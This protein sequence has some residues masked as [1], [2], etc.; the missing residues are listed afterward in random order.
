MVVG[1][2]VRPGQ[3]RRGRGGSSSSGF[4]RG[5]VVRLG[6]GLSKIPATFSFHLSTRY[7]LITFK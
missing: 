5:D 6:G 1:L 2:G 3:A 4:G 7:I